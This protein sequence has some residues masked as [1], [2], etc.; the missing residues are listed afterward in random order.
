MPPWVIVVVVVVLVVGV[1]LGPFYE[2]LRGWLGLP[3]RVVRV[4]ELSPSVVQPAHP[5]NRSQK[6][7][8]R[9]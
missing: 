9:R 2:A 6:T 8:K 7:R 3:G 1:F 4:R 5:P